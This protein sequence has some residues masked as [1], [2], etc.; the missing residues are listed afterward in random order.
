MRCRR[1]CV[2][3]GI[4]QLRHGRGEARHE[5]LRCREWLL[6]LAPAP[7]GSYRPF[8]VFVSDIAGRFPAGQHPC[9]FDYAV[10]DAEGAPRAVDGAEHA[11]WWSDASGIPPG[12]GIAL[13]DSQR[14]GEDP[15][16]PGL[17]CLR[18]LWEG[19]SESARHVR[20]GIAATR[21]ALPRE[22]LPMIIVHGRDDG[23]IPMA[24]S[25]TPYVQMLR[26]A[27]RD[28]TYWQVTDAQHFDA[29]LAFPD[30]ARRYVPL[31]P[32]VHAALDAVWAHLENPA[33]ALPADA[34][35]SPTHGKAD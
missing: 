1:R 18:S 15:D 24:F 3:H 19:D 11:L 7:A 5:T 28:V 17:D 13:R 4:L 21:A 23:L 35:L 14:A 22:H 8:P 2:R 29:F 34:V 16:L 31:L 25:S 10:L 33:V 20:E 27:D 26:A 6:R 32:Q 12:N 9:G 30:Y